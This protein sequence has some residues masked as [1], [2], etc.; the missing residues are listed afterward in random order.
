ML[1]GKSYTTIAS[2]HL[3]RSPILRLQFYFDGVH[4]RGFRLLRFRS[5][6]RDIIEFYDILLVRV[7]GAL[8]CCLTLLS[9]V[10]LHIS[11]AFPPPIRR[12]TNPLT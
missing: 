11:P 7:A 1:H 12:G 3:Q 9:A 8:E 4:N 5:A 2:A 10:T 6:Y